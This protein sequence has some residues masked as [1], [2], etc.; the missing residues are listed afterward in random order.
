MTVPELVMQLHLMFA[1]NMVGP[2]SDN[3]LYDFAT[4]WLFALRRSSRVL[5][6]LPLSL[7][8][9]YHIQLGRRHPTSILRRG[10]S[11]SDG[12]QS[13]IDLSQIKVA[14][15]NTTHSMLSSTTARE[16][17]GTPSTIGS[18][19]SSSPTACQGI[20]IVD[21]DSGSVHL[22]ADG[23]DWDDER[24]IVALRKYYALRHEAEDT[25]TESKRLWSDTP[26]SVYALQAFSPPPKNSE[27]MQA[28]LQHSVQTYGPLPS[29]LGP[30]RVRSR[31]QSCAS[32]YSSCHAQ[33]EAPA[34]P[35]P[36]R[37]SLAELHRAFAPPS[38]STPNAS[39]TSRTTTLRTSPRAS[40]HPPPPQGGWQP[41]PRPDRDHAT[42]EPLLAL[43]T[44]VA[45]LL[46][47]SLTCAQDDYAEFT[48]A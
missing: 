15:S 40:S 28:L 16:E 18:R 48:S 22:S 1:D 41:Y 33:L 34:S 29:E 38:W 32:P 36:P 42:H 19:K 5:A 44:A 27:G 37:P 30:R 45:R 8:H 20:F 23:V 24:G 6:Q 14:L 26:F 12:S 47:P 7:V 9:H 10:S 21:P 43:R 2:N 35:E 11:I 4:R 39:C 13:S 46:V 25:V 17:R 31:T 3:A